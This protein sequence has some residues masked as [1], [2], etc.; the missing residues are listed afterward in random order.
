[1]RLGYELQSSNKPTAPSL[2]L[3]RTTADHHEAAHAAADLHSRWTRAMRA[4]LGDTCC[5][6]LPFPSTTLQNPTAS[7][8][9]CS[10]CAACRPP[11]VHRD[12]SRQQVARPPAAMGPCQ[13]PAPCLPLI[14]ITVMASDPINTYSS[15]EP[16]YG[17]GERGCCLGL[18]GCRRGVC[19]WHLITVLHR[20]SH[21]RQDGAPPIRDDQGG[22][23]G[24]V[25]R[26]PGSLCALPR[27]VNMLRMRL[28]APGLSCERRTVSRSCRRLPPPPA[29]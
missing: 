27:C 28:I 7:K 15:L 12:M 24:A 10:H 2:H 9:T 18:L 3:P 19:R 6:S 4:Q 5:C 20:R 14:G 25:R 23:R 21:S 26:P 13:P 1:M 17:D 16:V 11:D 29:C 8:C 22:L